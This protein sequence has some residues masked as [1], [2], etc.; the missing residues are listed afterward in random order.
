MKRRAL[1]SVTDKTGIVEFARALRDL[2]YALLSTGGTFE[3]L[4][5]SA[6]L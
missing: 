6:G 1:L 5:K 2:G 3:H 4:R